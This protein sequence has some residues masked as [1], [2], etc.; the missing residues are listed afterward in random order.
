MQA[1]PYVLIAV[2]TALSPVLADASPVKWHLQNVVFDDGATMTG[3]FLYD[4]DT[5]TYSDIDVTT[6]PGTAI[7]APGPE[8]TTV[9]GFQYDRISTRLPGQT[10]SDSLVYIDDSSQDPAQEGAGLVELSFRAPLT[11]VGGFVELAG[12]SGPPVF[13]G[14]AG[15]LSCPPP[16]D[17]PCDGEIR[18]RLLQRGVV[19]SLEFRSVPALG[20]GSLALLVALLGSLGAAAVLGTSAATA[21]S[22]VSRSVD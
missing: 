7:I 4:A 2:V 6:S 8:T 17:Y 16:L 21:R 5:N 1:L 18:V 11:N 9:P 10:P 12:V 22:R 20:A 15:E 13:T 3:S 14:F 19:T